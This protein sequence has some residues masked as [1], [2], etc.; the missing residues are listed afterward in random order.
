GFDL[1]TPSVPLKKPTQLARK[2]AAEL[3][4]VSELQVVRHFTRLSSWN[5][6]IDLGTFPLGSCTMKYN[7][8][9]NEELAA[10]TGFCDVHPELPTEFCQ[11]S[12]KLIYLLEKALASIVG[13]D[14]CTVQPA[15]G[16]VGE[17]TGLTLIRA[18]HEKHGGH[19]KYVLIPDSAH[20]T[21]P[22]SCILA[23]YEAIPLKVGKD[24]FMTVE[25][26]EE[27]I[28]KYG[29]DIA[30]LMTTNPNTLGVF[31]QNIAQIAERLHS[32]GAQLC[33]DGAN[34]N[35]ILGIAKP[36]DMGVDVMQY[37]LHK[38]FSTPH[39]GGGPG[40]GPVACRS[41]LAPF[42]PNPRVVERDGV[43]HVE[44][45]PDSIGKVKGAFGNF[46]VMVRALAYIMNH[47]SDGLRRVSTN[48]VI[49]ANY[50]RAKL[51]KAYQLGTST[52]HFHECVLSD[53]KQIEQN[54][55]KTIQIAK[56]LM[57]YGYHPPTVYFPLTV[58]GA[59]LIEP[60]ETES[61]QELDELADAF[62]EIAKRIENKEETFEKSPIKTFVGKVDEVGAAR[63]PILSL[64]DRTL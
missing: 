3:P 64:D 52:A 51:Q 18:F 7:P 53:S 41:H 35:A 61:L 57:D 10:L 60:T 63:K 8:R 6:A 42:L 24:G 39:G 47:G 5:Y 56:A 32:I 22:A 37:N 62:L 13:L 27:A 23:G 58:P 26:V 36:G 40:S 54:G 45:L 21:N 50:L 19:R 31:E 9:I 30:A 25:L 34:M 48:A 15:A 38:T 4:E 43:Y 49:N 28:A 29:R 11:G 59:M 16:A 2:Q 12:L 46:G 1:P 17:F 33:M 20:G 44:H 55:I 14:F